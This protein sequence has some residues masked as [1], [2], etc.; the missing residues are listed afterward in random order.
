M[1][2]RVRMGD[3]VTGARRKFDTKDE[4]EAWA[5]Q[6]KSSRAQGGVSAMSLGARDSSDAAVA[7]KRLRQ[8][9]PASTLLDAVQFFLDNRPN[10]TAPL[11]VE[12]I[13][14]DLLA[15]KRR[16]GKSERYIKDLQSRC[17]AF[18]GEFRGRMA[19]EISP[20]EIETWLDK[21]YENLTTRQNC[22]RILQV[23]FSYA[24]KQRHINR[25]PM[26]EI[27][28]PE[29]KRSRVKIFS[30]E[31]T[32][33]LL[34]AAE[35]MPERDEIVPALA[36]GFFAG[37]RPESELPE[38]SWEKID[39]KGR[40]ID[41]DSTKN[42][43]EESASIRYIEISDNLLAWLNKYIKKSGTICT[44]GYDRYHRLLSK[45]V[46]STAIPTEGRAI[47]AEGVKWLH[48]GLRHSF[49]S[50]HFAMWEDRGKTMAQ[51]GHTNPKTF[52]R[53]YRRRVRKDLA[54]LYWGI[55][56]HYNF[57]EDHKRPK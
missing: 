39:M 12:L 1:D 7:L 49:G 44:G 4:A 6:Q 47:A 57:R 27:E 26:A 9:A 31:D 5:Q 46:E 14:P 50:Y 56:P 55:V 30:I 17:G 20:S 29:I 53:H 45:V 18:V 52:D 10:I 35:K 2:A 22:W 28:K 48:D 15:S 23:F 11:A 19:H 13:V 41:I 33:R 43:E 16:K 8:D 24:L 40:L 21:S 34:E 54:S 37:V 25:A 3:E 36:L 42:E 38:I 51:M 32:Q